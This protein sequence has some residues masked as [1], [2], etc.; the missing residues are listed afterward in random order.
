MPQESLVAEEI[1][2]SSKWF[3]RLASRM[4]SNNI[5]LCTSH[6]LEFKDDWLIH[7]SP[8]PTPIFT[9]P[10]RTYSFPSHYLPRSSYQH[11]KL[12]VSHQRLAVS[13]QNLKFR[14]QNTNTL[15][16]MWDVE[17]LWIFMILYSTLVYA[18][19]IYGTIMYFFE[20]LWW[21]PK[22]CFFSIFLTVQPINYQH[23]LTA[24]A[25]T[26]VHSNQ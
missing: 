19:L 7:S 22:C 12:P 13:H 14:N 1:I 17:S 6:F 15:Q 16:V 21:A 10:F 18:V 2:W 24:W 25:D 9:F 26:A 4:V 5:K 11:N 20:Q 3:S 8:F 23:L